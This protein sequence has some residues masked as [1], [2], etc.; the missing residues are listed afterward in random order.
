[1][2]K[3]LAIIIWNFIYFKVLFAASIQ[4]A[5]LPTSTGSIAWWDNING[6]E[7][8][9]DTLS[10]VKDTIFGVLALIA[11]W[12]FLYL[13]YKL[14]VAKWNEEEFKKA[15]LSFVY[16]VVGIVLVSLAWALVSFV[17]WIKF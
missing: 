13:W 9:I 3:I 2:K 17:S 7:I 6:D 5:I 15:L 1:M 14:V 10:Y 4:D 8:I 16:A 11:I 12:V